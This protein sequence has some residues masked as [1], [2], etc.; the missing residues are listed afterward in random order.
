MQTGR[1][2]KTQVCA[3][4]QSEFS[5][6]HSQFQSRGPEPEVADQFAVLSGTE[7]EVGGRLLDGIVGDPADGPWGVGIGWEL[8]LPFGLP[9]YLR[10]DLPD[11]PAIHWFAFTPEVAAF[12]RRSGQAWAAVVE[13]EN[14]AT[15]PT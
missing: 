14:A 3:G 5:I 12:A 8:P 13:A 4:R 15:Q 7:R 2:G 10:G 1:E 11:A 6:L 9:A